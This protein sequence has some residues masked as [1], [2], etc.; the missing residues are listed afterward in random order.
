MLRAVIARKFPRPAELLNRLGNLSGLS[1]LY[2]KQ[3]EREKK[4]CHELSDL[5]CDSILLPMFHISFFA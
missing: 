4:A 2:R 1:G 3:D 5:S